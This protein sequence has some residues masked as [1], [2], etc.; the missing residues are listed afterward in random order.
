[1]AGRF[2]EHMVQAELERWGWN[3]CNLNA[4][5][6][7]APGFD[8]LAWKDDADATED[9]ETLPRHRI[10]VRVKT[11]SPGRRR[12]VFGIEAKGKPPDVERIESN[13][14]TVLVSMGSER[15]GDV[16]YVVPTC[17]LR[18]EMIRRWNYL[19]GDSPPKRKEAG[20]LAL[21]FY[22]APKKRPTEPGYGLDKKWKCYLNAWGTLAP[23]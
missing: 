18:N 1:M 5:F 11:A 3:T 16:F 4:G 20:I 21:H 13:D 14:Y 23:T 9:A 17:E 19:H 22:D 8:L 7:N 12:F 2:G 15:D 6:P 10:Y